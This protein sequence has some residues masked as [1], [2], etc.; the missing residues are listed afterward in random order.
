MQRIL[1]VLSMFFTLA[2]SAQDMEIALWDLEIPD[3]KKH[4]D[5]QEEQKFDDGKLSRASKVSEPKIYAFFAKE[6]TS[7]T[8][9]II[10]PGGG[11][12]HLS[13]SKEGFKVAEWLASEGI[14]AFVVK[15]RLPDDRI[16]KDKSVGP[17]QD[18]QRA[19]RLIRHNAEKWNLD[20]DKIGIMGFSAGGHLAATLSTHYDKKVYLNKIEESA[21]PDFSILAYPV[22][23]LTSAITH[24]GSRRRLLGEN[25]SDNLVT[26]FSNEFQVSE[27]AP[28]TF[29][30]HALDDH[31]VPVENTLNYFNA[32]KENNIP[33][34][35]HIY[36]DGGHGFGLAEHLPNN[37][38]P[39][40]LLEWLKTQN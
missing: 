10:F 24:E 19:V 4:S 27:N 35:L 39:K 1:I 40:L 6:N 13:M 16:M 9:V 3:S 11:Y 38:W 17:L 33:T 21:R 31:A 26:Q 30:V 32:L 25:P 7:K 34:E 15:Y 18:A 12:S 14:S 37:L 2:N 5:Y 23:S 22:I 29:L 28:P 20:S 8:A 36:N